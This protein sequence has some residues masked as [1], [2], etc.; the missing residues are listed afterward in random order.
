MPTKSP[1]VDRSRDMDEKSWWDLWNTSYRTKD[2]NDATSSELFARAAAAI[3]QLTQKSSSRVLE[4]AC[5]TGT[6][7][8]MLVSSGYHGLDLS[9]AAID[10]ARQKSGQ[11]PL[12]A[13]ASAPKYEVA[14]F[15]DWPLPAQG[16]DVTVC[17]DAISSFRDQGLAMRK[18]A[19]SLRPGGHLVLTT[20]NPFVYRRIRRTAGV[21]LESGPVCNWLSRGEL[22]SLIS[23]AELTIERSCSIMPRGNMGLLR[24]IN[25]ARLNNALG[26]GIATALKRLK[27]LV[28]LGQYRLVVARKKG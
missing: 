21:K 14:D 22:H 23:Q 4:I 26:P 9:P 20:I 25:S 10:L 16:F 24:V 15:H 2:D 19:Q 5:G 13:G 12:P 28:G 3:N 6:L 1:V 18:I 7:S 11:N 17:I 27:E 8:R